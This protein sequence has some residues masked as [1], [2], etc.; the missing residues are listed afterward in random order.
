MK[1]KAYA[2]LNLA[3]DILGQ[4]PNGYH[5]IRSVFYEYT[6]LYDEVSVHELSE[7][8]VSVECDDHTVPRDSRNLCYKAARAMQKASGI[9]RGLHIEI[10]KNIPSGSGLG[11]GSSDAAATIK[12]INQIWDLGYEKDKLAEIAASI[13]MDVPFFIYG[14]LAIGEHYGEK[15][16][17]LKAKLEFNVKVLFSKEKSPTELAYKSIKIHKCGGETVKTDHLLKAI[18]SKSTSAILHNIHND[19]D[20]LLLKEGRIF[21]TFQHAFAREASSNIKKLKAAGAKATILC[22]SGSAVVGFFA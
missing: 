11:A 6:D 19:F 15:I 2:K 4:D 8:G 17:P 18:K 13:G 14:G 5:Q 16:T 12:L 10:K 1:M 21:K 9:N 7:T 22:G 3:L 20:Q